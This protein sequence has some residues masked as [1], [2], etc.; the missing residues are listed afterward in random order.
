[1]DVGKRVRQLR[2]I[3]NITTIELSKQCGISQSTISKL[4]N[5]NRIP[6]VPT[7]E[8]ICKALNMTLADFF[9]LERIPE[10]AD[11]YLIELICTARKLNKEQL[12]ALSLFLKTIIQEDLRPLSAAE[13][14]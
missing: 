12:E 2:K 9:S 3:H 10:P 1:M 11:E 4:E 5:G 6:D 14:D 13:S 7:L 8:K